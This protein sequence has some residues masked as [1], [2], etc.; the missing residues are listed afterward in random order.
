MTAS[1]MLCHSPLV[2]SHDHPAWYLPQL[3]LIVFQDIANQGKV[4]THCSPVNVLIHA[5]ATY[6]Q[7]PEISH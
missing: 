3:L 4:H 6:N 1:S 5:L 7:M 2:S